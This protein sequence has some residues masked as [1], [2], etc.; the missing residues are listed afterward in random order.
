M[1]AG[2]TI[3]LITETLVCKVMSLFFNTLSRFVITFLPR[4]KCLNFIA[5]VAIHSD[6]EASEIKSIIASTFPLRFAHEVMGLQ[7]M[8][9]IFFNVYS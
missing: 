7:A 3:A 8:I 9:L 5:I 6:F 4:S 1:N 2:K